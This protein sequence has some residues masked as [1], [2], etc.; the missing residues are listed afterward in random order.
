[1][2]VN[3]PYIGFHG[4][5]EEKNYFSQ[6]YIAAKGK[7]DV[8]LLFIEQGLRL[9]KGNGLFVLFVQLTLLRESMVNP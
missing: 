7:Y 8:Y 2:I 3:P 6:K 1:V 4:F 9:Q 5:S